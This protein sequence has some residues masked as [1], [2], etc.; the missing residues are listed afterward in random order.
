MMRLAFKKGYSDCWVES[1]LDRA[2]RDAGRPV[3]TVAQ[4]GRISQTAKLIGDIAFY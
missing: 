3:R 2:G 1:E 4:E